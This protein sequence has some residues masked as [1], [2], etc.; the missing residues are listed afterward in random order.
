MIL[1]KCRLCNGKK[2]FKFLDL[3]FHPPSDQFRKKKELNNPTTYYPLQVY[4]CLA[5][6]FKQLNY[7]VEPK[8]LYQEN[9]PYESSLTNQGKKH[10]SEFA[11]SILNE[12]DFNKNDLVET[13][14]NS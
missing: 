1:S 4:S 10:Y 3:G 6:G 13:L 5:C 12:Y 7:V 8:I 2:L 9:Y 14:Y 11:Q